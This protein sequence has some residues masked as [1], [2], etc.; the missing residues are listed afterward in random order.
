MEPSERSATA[1]LDDTPDAVVR[2]I[3]ALP[4]YTVDQVKAFLEAAS[5]ERD[6]LLLEVA[7]ATARML[8][9]EE[10]LA[11]AAELR[12]RL[13]AMVLD[14]QR[15]VA[16]RRADMEAAVAHIADAAEAEAEA[17]V[18]NARAEAAT[19][20]SRTALGRS[21]WGSEPRSPVIDLTLRTTKVV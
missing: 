2:E 8:A 12:S 17:I 4:A 10:R 11:A 6:R 3:G 16:R 20:R 9:A 7:D 5:E 15:I 14:A 1:G 19:L 21:T 13:G 18:A